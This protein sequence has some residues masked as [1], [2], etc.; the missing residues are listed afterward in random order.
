MYHRAACL[1]QGGAHM[2]LYIFL[3]LDCEDKVFLQSTKGVG[4]GRKSKRMSWPQENI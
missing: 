3:Y 1:P 2:Q 4:E